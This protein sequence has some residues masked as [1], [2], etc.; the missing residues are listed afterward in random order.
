M[1]D[2]IVRS[3]NDEMYVKD[4]KKD[5]SVSNSLSSDYIIQ[6][7]EIL[8]DVGRPPGIH[9]MIHQ[10]AHI[11]LCMKFGSLSSEIPKSSFRMSQSSA[12][13]LLDRQN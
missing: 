13:E 7:D 3:Y 11:G 10:Y 2:T 6:D 4:A 1:D 9:V 8:V 12:K 5:D